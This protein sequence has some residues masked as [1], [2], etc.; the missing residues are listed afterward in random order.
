MLKGI[1]TDDS[2]SVLKSLVVCQLNNHSRRTIRS[3][4]KRGG[5]ERDIPASDTAGNIGP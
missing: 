3:T 4:P 2:P 1:W 5:I